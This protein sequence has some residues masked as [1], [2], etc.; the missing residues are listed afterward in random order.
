MTQM[1]SP[2]RALSGASLATATWLST[3]FF[4][5]GSEVKPESGRPSKRCEDA[6]GQIPGKV[7]VVA[8]TDQCRSIPQ[9]WI[10]PT[11]P[12]SPWSRTH[13]PGTLCPLL[14]WTPTRRSLCA[15]ASNRRLRRPVLNRRVELVNVSNRFIHRASK[16]P[17]KAG[18]FT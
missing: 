6:Q 14:N 3:A 15:M 9:T 1:S 8:H 10:C 5:P 17:P 7:Y 18:P 4:R 13:P 12:Q 2:C 16:R 11:R